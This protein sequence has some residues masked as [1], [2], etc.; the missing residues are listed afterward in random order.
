MTSTSTHDE[1]PGQVCLVGAGPGDPGLLTLKGRDC[2]ARADVVFYDALVNPALLEH[3]RED[4]RIVYVGKKAGSHSFTQARINAMLAEAAEAGLRVCRLKGGDPFVFGRGGEEALYLRGRG[5]PVEV[6]PGVSAAIAAP[7]SAGIPVTH[8]G[9]A[10]SVRIVTGHEVVSGAEGGLPWDA[11]ARE[12]GTLVVLMGHQNLETIVQRL[13]EHGMP[14]S[15]P[16]AVISKATLPEQQTVVAPLGG[17]V[18]C[19]RNACLATP[20]TLVVG[21][22]VLLS[23]I[24]NNDSDRGDAGADAAEGNPT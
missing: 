14:G 3:A 17:I 9:S 24:L 1:H 10:A 7:A 22:V 16:A 12:S 20:A 13:L 23:G 11:F 4:A 15:T 5:I 21:E 8:R 6:V 19:A 18:Q 2:I